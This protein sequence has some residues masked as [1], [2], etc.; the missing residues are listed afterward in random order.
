MVKNE[1]LV[2]Q[3][4]TQ[5]SVFAIYGIKPEALLNTHSVTDSVTAIY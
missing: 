2:K 1:A 3:A 4:L 5:D